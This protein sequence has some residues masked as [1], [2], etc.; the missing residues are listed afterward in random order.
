MVSA[1]DSRGSDSP[2][3][4]DFAA[5]HT[6]R[7]QSISVI[8]PTF[9]RAKMLCDCIRSVLDTGYPALEVIVVDDCSPD[10]TAELVKSTFAEE[11]RVKYLRNE[12]NS[13]QAVSRNNGARLA[14]GDY[15]FFLDDDNVLCRDIFEE[16]LAAFERHPRAALVAPMAVHQASNKRNLIWTLGS[17]FNRWTS[18]PKDNLPNLPL[19]NLP[20]DHPDDFATTYSPNAFMVTREAFDKVGGMEESFVAIFEES[21]FGWKIIESG[22]EAYIASKAVTNHYGFLEPGCVSQL[23]QLGVE[24]PAR[25]YYFARNRLRFARRHFA[26]YQVV[27]ISLVFA[28]LSV[29][30]YGRVALKNKRPDIAWAYFKGTLRGILGLS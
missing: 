20:E 28:P 18:Q 12:R 25:T 19:E 10:N 24:R 6:M 4:M 27:V 26:W 1:T 13:F 7:H 23:R 22:Y 17:D 2:K 5:I 3:E 30:W 14:T 16:L 8:I 21:D 15:L 9:N 11:P 29:L